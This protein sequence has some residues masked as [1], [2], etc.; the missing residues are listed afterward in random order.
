MY[1]AKAP[2]DL[3]DLPVPR[4]D[5]VEKDF[6]VTLGYEATRGCPYTCSFCALTATRLPYRRRP[7]P[8][9][10][11]D[12]QAIPSGWSWLQRRYL[13]L[14]DNNLGVDR[15]Y[16]RELCEALVPLKYVW[17]TETSIDTITAES[18]KMLR[19]AGC[20]FVYTGLESLSEDSLLGTNKLHNK[21]SEYR[22]RLGYLHDNGILVM[23]IFLVGLDGDT[24]EYLR[25]LPD[26]AHDIGV[27]IPVFSMAAPIE[28]T[29]FHSEL[30]D[31]GRLLPGNILGGLD[32]MHLVYQPQHMSAE[33]VELALFECLR[34]A[35]SPH[36]MMRRILRR[37][38]RDFW[39][40]LAVTTAN[41]AFVPHH[42]A[43]R[44]SC[45]QRVNSRGPWPGT[46]PEVWAASD[47]GPAEPLV[48][49]AA[50]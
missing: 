16:L 46:D 9:V 19:R 1:T 5:L 49:K 26:L 35:N 21:V 33:E 47:P 38:G 37:V 23:S 7:V 8:H 48:R 30:R 3:S 28:G 17:A 36:R 27:D 4:Y 32:G 11:R 15:A 22:R 39:T 42:R 24:P 25:N 2:A 29:P 40:S 45:E 34:R 14:W 10:I 50:R 41:L 12:I 18:A 31:S 20:R 6:I 44:L 13:M 43:L